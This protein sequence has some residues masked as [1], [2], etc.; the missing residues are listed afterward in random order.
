MVEMMNLHK[1]P[2]SISVMSEPEV[3]APSQLDLTRSQ[4]I[5]LFQNPPSVE[6]E[7]SKVCHKPAHMKERI[8]EASNPGPDIVDP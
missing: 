2:D 1:E 3:K 4:I 7:I 6:R 5:S 8:G